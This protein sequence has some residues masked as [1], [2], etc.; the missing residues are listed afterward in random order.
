MC[1]CLQIMKDRVLL[2]YAATR[3]LQS[4]CWPTQGTVA[5]ALLTAVSKLILVWH[6]YVESSYIQHF[7]AWFCL[8]SPVGIP[9]VPNSEQHY[10]LAIIQQGTLVS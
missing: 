6:L 4:I 10:L 2:R 5:S 7:C 3:A 9:E 1:I 8:L